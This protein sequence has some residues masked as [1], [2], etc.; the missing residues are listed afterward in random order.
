VPRCSMSPRRRFSATCSRGTIAVAVTDAVLGRDPAIS[1]ALAAFLGP[2]FPVW[3]G[4]KGG[5]GVAIYIGLLLGFQVWLAFAAFRGPITGPTAYIGLADRD[6]AVLAINEINAVG[7]ING[8]KI[9]MILEDDGHSQAKALVAVKKLIDEDK[10]F[11]VLIVAGSDSTSGT[12]DYVKEAG[13][14][15]KAVQAH[16]SAKS[17]WALIRSLLTA[18]SDRADGG[19]SLHQGELN[20]PPYRCRVPICA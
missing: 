20:Q 6:G 15:R 10:V 9:N 13:F 4:F 16:S 2:L 3:L 7:G 12:I 19:A 14:S 8:R 17:L 5:K 18:G 1:A 11:M